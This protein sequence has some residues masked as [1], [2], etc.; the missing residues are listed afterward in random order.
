M[1]V[2]YTETL[3][4]YPNYS[5]FTYLRGSIKLGCLPPS[6]SPIALVR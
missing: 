4:P 5:S 1:N 2:A 6:H 3:N